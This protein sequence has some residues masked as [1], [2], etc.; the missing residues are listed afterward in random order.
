M[1]KNLRLLFVLIFS[2][3][4]HLAFGFVVADIRVRRVERPVQ[5]RRRQRDRV[6][7][8]GAGTMNGIT[9]LGHLHTTRRHRDQRLGV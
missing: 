3:L 1:I 2:L 8:P 7:V 5:R 4:P 6:D 9:P